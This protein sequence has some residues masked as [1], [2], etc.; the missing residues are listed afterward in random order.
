MWAIRRL[1]LIG[2]SAA[3]VVAPGPVRAQEGATNARPWAALGLYGFGVRA[4]ADL[5]GDDQAVVGATADLG[6]VYTPRLRTRLS[7]ELGFLNGPNSYVGNVEVLYRFTPESSLAIPYLGGGI[8]LAGNEACGA[9]PDCPGLWV[10]F[11]LGFELR[12]RE[13]FNWLIEYHPQDA[14]RRHRL[15]IGLTTRLPEQ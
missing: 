4:G 7:G 11:A 15:L 1:G 5:R 9:D 13:T 8:A 10:Q 2:A 6:Y 14:F 12:L 3:V